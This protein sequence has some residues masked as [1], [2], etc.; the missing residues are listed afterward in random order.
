MLRVAASA[1]RMHLRCMYMCMPAMPKLNAKIVM[2]KEQY[3]TVMQQ[4]CSND[5]NCATV[6]L[7]VQPHR[8]ARTHTTRPQQG[9]KK[10]GADPYELVAVAVCWHIGSSSLSTASALRPPVL[11]LCNSPT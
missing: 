4:P 10:R 8:H 3:Y 7:L 5:D 11:L 9:H 2:Y 1:C 6:I